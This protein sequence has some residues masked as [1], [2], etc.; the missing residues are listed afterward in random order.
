M[1]YPDDFIN[2]IICGDCLEVMKGVPDKSI[3]LIIVDSPYQEGFSNRFF[4]FK[5]KLVD[6]GQMLWFTQPTELYDMPERPKQILIWKEPMSPKPKY[7]RY[8]EF[9]DFICWYA[10][11]E[12]TF[13]NL[14]WNLMS[15]VFED[16]IIRSERLHKWEKPL[17]MIEKLILIHTNENDIVLDPF[18]GS[19]TTA[20]ACMKWNRNFIGIDISEEYCEIARKRVKESK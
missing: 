16:F 14:L 20:E 5:Y 9:L 13:N 11:G 17:S 6:N 7:R 10:Y 1:K 4:T 15:S 18:L 19:G 3:D 8:K 12:Y 2:K